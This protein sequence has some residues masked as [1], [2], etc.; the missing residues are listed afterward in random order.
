MADKLATMATKK[1]QLEMGDTPVKAKRAYTRKK[2]IARTRALAK[3]KPI[4]KKVATKKK[5]A[6]T[7]IARSKNYPM[8]DNIIV[9]LIKA[10]K[11]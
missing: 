8:D 7:K 10:P 2:P 6:K 4:A 3:K 9:E 11:P 1:A 5:P